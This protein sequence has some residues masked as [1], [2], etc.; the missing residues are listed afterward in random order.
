M[1]PPPFHYHDPHSLDEALT[2]LAGLDNAKILAGGQSLMPMLNMRFAQPDDIVDLNR[3]GELSFIRETGTGIEIGAM[4]RQ[5][6]LESAAPI[7]D[8]CPLMHEALGRIG[9]R[10]TRN[11]G[12]LGGSLC[13]LDPAAELPVVAMALDATIH[14]RNQGGERTLP[15]ADFPAFYMT[16][17]IEP[18]E[19]VTKISFE[20]WSAGHGAAF[21]EFTRRHGD[22]AVVAAAAMLELGDD[23]AIRRAAVV[24]GGVGPGPLR[25]AAA[26][27]AI[28]GSRG[29]AA[30]REAAA[31]CREI[32]AM[33]DVH[34]P[35]SY[36]RHLAEVLT[37]R[38][39]A[40]AFAR[41]GG[42]SQS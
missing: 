26:E 14:L 39:L 17:A 23:G 2:L 7:R 33:E 29:G 30:F 27:A 18:D 24:L 21:V 40:S 15:M 22:F 42:E 25:C 32:D 10:A 8:R 20:P 13:H 9:H 19:I 5:H 36:R 16:P 1:K 6:E 38:A 37:Q 4:T 35:S 3:I 41:A 12:T 34:N 11:R 31:T 28:M